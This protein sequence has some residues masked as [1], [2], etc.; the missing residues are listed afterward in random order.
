[1]PNT[2]E[3][4]ASSTVG[5]GGAASIAFSSI[6]STYTDLCVKLSIRGNSSFSYDTLYFRLNGSSATIYTRRTL[7]GNGSGIGS[8]TSTNDAQFMGEANGNTATANTFCN[9]EIYFPN[10]AGST[11]KSYSAD[12][13]Q[14]NNSTEAYAY[15]LAGFFDSTAAISSISLFTSSGTVL[16]HSTAYLYGVKNA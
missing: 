5:S 8:G 6:P 9:G 16:Q 7:G 12:L 13:V 1:M 14:E 15:L 2:F 4:I 11:K 10:Y 3:L